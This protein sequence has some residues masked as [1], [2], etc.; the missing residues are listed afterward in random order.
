MAHRIGLDDRARCSLGRLAAVAAV[1]LLI[2]GY[3]DA[4]GGP[5]LLLGASE[6]M[7][8]WDPSRAASIG[9]ELGLGAYRLT[10]VWTPG[11][12][13]ID[14]AQ[15]GLLD[16]SFAALAHQRIVLAVYGAASATPRDQASRVQFCTFLEN[17]LGRYSRIRDIVVWNEANNGY[18]WQPQYR[19]GASAAPT[20]YAQLLST[21]YPTLHEARP[22]VNLI[23]ALAA[24]GG[25]DHTKS[26]SAHAPIAFIR[27]M[28]TA[29]RVLH[30]QGPLFDTL[31]QNIYGE[32]AREPPNTPHPSSGDVGE[33]D[34][35][36]LVA[37]LR[38]AFTGTGQ[39]APGPHLSIWY[40]EDG[41]QTSIEPSKRDIYTGV[42]TVPTVAT[43]GSTPTQSTQLVAA[44]KLAYCQR[45]VGA[46]FN[47]LLQDEPELTRWQSGIL[48]ADGTPKPAYNALRQI[49][50]AVSSNRIACP[51]P[52]HP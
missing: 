37:A 47:L 33:G 14:A 19:S 35:D 36:K 32:T 2:T 23:A 11:Q 16:R 31:G 27:A 39:P 46:F 44:I 13:Q 20:A 45:H 50:A 48:W 28:G 26:R 18:F 42:E 43:A 9:D 6:D 24:H 41:F 30:L 3:H 4:R 10:V 17:L 21:C 29:Y 49:R 22:N 12:P 40:M 25:G 15:A 52:T 38:A 51:K 34:Y 1:L 8:K 7:S 5:G